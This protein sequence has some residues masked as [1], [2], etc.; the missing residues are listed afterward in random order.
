MV[1]PIPSSPVLQNT[2]SANTKKSSGKGCSGVGGIG[3]GRKRGTLDARDTL[4]DESKELYRNEFV[5][6]DG[7]MLPGCCE[8]SN[9]GN[10]LTW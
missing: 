7:K 10:I 8:C 4:G 3:L 5:Q 1:I 6:D 9:V 2:N